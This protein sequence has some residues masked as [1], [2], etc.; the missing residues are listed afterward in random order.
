M[1]GLISKGE[2]MRE[3]GPFPVKPETGLKDQLLAEARRF[4]EKHYGLPGDRI[5]NACWMERFGI[6]TAFVMEQYGEESRPS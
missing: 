3:Y 5:T 6:L 2:A 1:D 4:M